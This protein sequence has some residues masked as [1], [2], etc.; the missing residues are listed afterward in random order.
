MDRRLSPFDTYDPLLATLVAG[1]ALSSAP[2][3]P[4]V[5]CGCWECHK[6]RRAISGSCHA[7][8]KEATLMLG[9]EAQCLWEAQTPLFLTARRPTEATR[10]RP[11]WQPPTPNIKYN[12]TIDGP[13]LPTTC[14]GCS[15]GFLA[16]AAM[17]SKCPKCYL[18]RKSST[19][20]WAQ[21]GTIPYNASF[22]VRCTVCNVRSMG[23][24]GAFGDASQLT[25]CPSH[26]VCPQ[27][28]ALQSVRRVTQ[29]DFEDTLYGADGRL[30][31]P[32]C[33]AKH[34]I[35]S[36]FSRRLQTMVLFRSAPA[37]YTGY[38]AAHCA[39]VGLRW[40][41]VQPSQGLAVGPSSA[42]DAAMLMSLYAQQA[43]PPHIA[44]KVH[45]GLALLT[46]T[47]D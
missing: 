45:L 17:A 23:R 10:G 26:G 28:A 24:R 41:L 14:A 43:L 35:V 13:W 1:R 5:I 37:K 20:V 25:A 12:K 47:L 9:Q 32:L 30:L 36:V 18:A 31:A 11:T 7:V 34:H 6:M 16:P 19:L 29:E 4:E 27:T 21:E 3:D 2:T 44:K 40:A 22:E 42:A 46:S 8:L 39:A 33:S 15:L 38:L